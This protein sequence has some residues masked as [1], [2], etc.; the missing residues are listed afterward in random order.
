L[1]TFDLE[2]D[3]WDKLTPT[4]NAPDG[5]GGHSVFASDGKIYIYGG[6]NSEM[7]YNN[8]LIYDLEKNEW[9]DPDIYNEIPR[10]NHSSLL[11]E[12]IP[13]WKFF[14]FGGECLE[15]Q[16]GTPRSFGSYVDSSCYLDLGTIQWRT[17]ASDP[18]VFA[19]IPAPREYAAMAYDERERRLIVSGGWCNGWFD[20][21]YTLNVAK[22]VGPSYAITEADPCLGQLSGGVTL[23]IKGQGFKDHIT[24]LFTLGTKP[25][26]TPTKQTISVQGQ[27]VS[28][29]ECTVVTPNFENFGP[30]ECVIQLSVANGDMTNTW[31]NFQYFLNT[32]AHKSLA[33]G[34]GLLPNVAVG[35][36]VEFKIIAR[37]DLGENRTSGRDTFEV[38]VKKLLP[39][40]EEQKGAE[41]YKPEYEEIPCEITDLD[42]GQYD[43]KYQVAEPGEVTVAIHFLNDKGQ[44]VPIRGSPYCAQFVDGISA[45]D[46]TMTGGAMAKHIQKEIERLQA[47]LAESKKEVTTKEKDIKNVKVLLQIKEKVEQTNESADRVTLEIDQLDECLKL[48]QAHKL[49]KDAQLK[50][51][52][53]INKEW[54][55]LKK[56]VKDTKKEIAPLVQQESDKNKQNI[57]KLEEDIVQFNQEMK[58]REFFQY[59]C[60]TKTAQEKLNGVFDEL[61]TFEDQIKDYGDNARKFGNPEL[62]NKAIKDIETIKITVNNMN[63][64]WEHIAVCQGKFDGYMT[65]KWTG[66]DT[67]AMDTEVKNLLKA[68]KEKPVEKKANAYQ[69]ILE[70]IK[71][72]QIFLPLVTDLADKAMRDRHWDS[73]KAKVGKQFTIDDNLL[74]KDI[75]D[76]NLGNY[77]EDVE[78]ITDQAKQEAKMESTLAILDEKWKDVVFEFRAHKDSGVHMMKLIEEDFDM[79]EENQVQVQSMFSSRYL[80]TFEDR[81]VYWQKA[82]AGISEINI[83]V[84]EVQRSWSFL[85]NLFIHSDEV[86]KEL[87]RESEKFVGIDKEVR[88]ILADGYKHQ[89][90]LSFCTQETVLPRLEKVAEDLNICEKALNEF[91]D[92]KRM[93]FPRF[94]FVS[95]ADLL[96]ILSNGN[97][98]TKIMKHMPKIIS[99]METLE[100]L[101]EGQRPFAKGMHACVGKEYV[102]FTVELKLLGKVEVY[103]QEVI[104]TMRKSLSDISKRSFKK[105][106]ELDKESWLAADPAQVTLLINNCCWVIN[107]EK[108]FKEM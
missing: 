68:L 64:L 80:A 87:P 59:K 89:K 66:I 90:A 62:I 82:L 3:T 71:K 43:C 27:Y 67:D 35:V 39:V 70:E 107:C 14:I 104:N 16:E 41:D 75:Y 53:K 12:A 57:K 103:L 106:G 17:Y 31:V 24:V 20:D 86:K 26:D 99:A 5:R 8:V 105:F 72:W 94:Y 95:P 56:L 61:K 108:A 69:G 98:P 91:M 1:H 73:I 46:N 85:E 15:Y 4:N 33:Y 65:Q 88:D 47:S 2:T 100:L 19:N 83:A 44:M 54:V 50:L 79:L 34:P 76:L 102:E 38:F 42:N 92:S 77:K 48:F 63:G 52:T 84:G 32:R 23:N 97:A 37:N 40:P 96:D 36:P 51:L 93:A 25:V 13:T 101:E 49:S 58:K 10:W 60:G 55:D 22:I 18:E 78:E 6:W 45:K 74:L 9:S 7:Q 29:N 28:D 11:V 30:K 21:I 81:I